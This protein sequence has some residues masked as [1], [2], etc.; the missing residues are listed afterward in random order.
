MGPLSENLARIRK[1]RD[2]SQ[3]RLAEAAS[4]GVDTIAR[5]EQGTRT[6]SRPETLRRIAAALEV[7]VDQLLGTMPQR[8]AAVDVAPLRR[9]VTAGQHIPGL[10]DFAEDDET[11]S[12]D[13]LTLAA[14]RAWRAY[15]GG[16]HAGLLHAL[17]AVLVDARRVVHTTVDEERA[18]AYRVL[19]T[20]YRL[21]AGLA[22]RLG[23][24]DLA[25]TSAERALTAARQCDSPEIEEAISLRYLAWTLVRQGRAEDAER[26]AVRAAEKI[27]PGI[28]D[29]DPTRAGVFGNLMFNAASA[30]L[31]SGHPSRADDLLAEADA[32]AARSKEDTASEAAIFGPRVA[33]LQR[34]DSIARTDDPAK[35]L[36]AAERLPVARGTVPAFWEAGH[37]LRLAAAALA[38]R[39]D[40]QALAFLADARDLAPDWARCQPLGT[41]TMRSLVDRA[42]RRRGAKFAELAEHYG[43][44]PADD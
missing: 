31:T 12:L 28:F 43:I 3:E 24:D 4:V 5:I 38:V 35:A 15:V 40:G 42:A 14:H 30:A 10:T 1:A 7:T 22:G 34:I 21:G 25:W 9:A 11:V 27:Q 41:A 16:R 13:N 18:V 17:P 36:C 32:A 26:V 2:L 6:S 23:L 19:S 44:V 33:A 20:A 29:R 37:R 39:R 8:Y